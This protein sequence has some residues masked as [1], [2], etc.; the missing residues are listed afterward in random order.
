MLLLFWDLPFIPV[1][2]THLDNAI[3]SFSDIIENKRKPTLLLH[4]C[5][6]PCST[7]VIER[8]ISKYRI[9]VFF[10]NPNITDPIEYEK[11]KETQLQFINEY[12]NNLMEDKINFIEGEYL[13][14]IHI[15]RVKRP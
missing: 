13:S 3:L 2:Y 11:R 6:G 14:L 7:A 10:Y 15:L 9:T 5:C 1:S 12:N 8:L 4:S